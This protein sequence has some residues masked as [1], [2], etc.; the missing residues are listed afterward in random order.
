VCQIFKFLATKPSAISQLS[1]FETTLKFTYGKVE[2][3]NFPG[4][5]LSLPVEETPCSTGRER[6]GGKSGREE[7]WGEEDKGM[8][9]R[10]GRGGTEGLKEQE[11][12]DER[13]R[14][15]GRGIWTPP[16]FQTDRCHW[17]IGH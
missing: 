4:T 11:G 16:M 10:K 15:R 7:G 2:F 5:D 8:G 13:R 6:E 1:S 12:K 14:G 9:S 3:Q 17:H